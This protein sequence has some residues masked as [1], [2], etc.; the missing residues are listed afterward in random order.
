L[1]VQDSCRFTRM[2]FLKTTSPFYSFLLLI[3]ITV[4]ILFSARAKQPLPQDLQIAM[5]KTK[6]IDNPAQESRD[7]GKEFSFALPLT[8]FE[9]LLLFMLGTVLLSIVTG[10]NLLR[11]G[12]INWHLHSHHQTGL[13]SQQKFRAPTAKAGKNKAA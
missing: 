1:A 3:F 11:S 5:A 8:H 7:Y 6:T 9:P 4:G 12:K 13:R 10:V 2:K